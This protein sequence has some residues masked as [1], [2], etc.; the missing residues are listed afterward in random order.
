MMGSAANNSAPDP[1]IH[2][3]LT[4]DGQ[5]HGPLFDRELS[6]RS[7]DLLWRDGWT[8]WA[9]VA[10]VFRPVEPL[11]K[12]GIARRATPFSSARCACTCVP[13][14]RLAS[15]RTRHRTGLVGTSVIPEREREGS[16]VQ[17]R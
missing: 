1:A 6:E 2:W 9:P 10:V 3:Y 8:N 17:S 15:I 16:A 14:W 4:R 11:Q 12:P 5:Q 7:T 13:N